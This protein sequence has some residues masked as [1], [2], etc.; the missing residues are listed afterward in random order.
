MATSETLP[1]FI[2]IFDK[3]INTVWTVKL[4]HGPPKCGR[5]ARPMR[6]G[7]DKHLTQHAALRLSSAQQHPGLLMI[8]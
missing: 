3:L 6:E 7:P 1:A 5:R 8:R 4:V 2:H